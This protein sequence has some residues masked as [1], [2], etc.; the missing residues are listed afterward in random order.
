M[1]SPKLI[2]QIAAKVAELTSQ[3][4]YYR[5]IPRL[6]TNDLEVISGLKAMD[7]AKSQVSKAKPNTKGFVWASDNPNTASTYGHT[8]GVV[9]PLELDGA[10]DVVVDA[11][12]PNELVTPGGWDNADPYD[13]ERARAAKEQTAYT[14]AHSMTRDDF[15]KKYGPTFVANDKGGNAASEVAGQDV[16]GYY[17]TYLGPNAKTTVKMGGWDGGYDGQPE[18]AIQWGGGRYSNTHPYFDAYDNVN[19]HPESNRG[20]G[21]DEAWKA[22]GRPI[23]TAAAMYYGVGALN[24]ALGAGAAAGTGGSAGIGSGTV[25]GGGAA[26]APT[27]TGLAGYMGMAPG[28]ADTALNTG[29]L[30]TGMSLV[31]GKNIGDSLK[32]GATSALLSP[33]SSY[34]GDAVGGGYTG[35]VAGNT[36]L[37]GVQ[38]AINGQGFGKGLQDGLVNGLVSS[39]GT[40]MGGLAKGA[41]GN[42]FAGTAANS[43]TQSTLRGRDPKAT[44]DSLATQYASGELTDLT[45]LPPQVANLVVN[46]AQNRKPTASQAVGALSQMGN[47]VGSRKMKQTAVGG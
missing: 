6:A 46:L 42:N 4:T 43:L 20:N 38:G 19:P 18:T 11:G 12:T 41:T 28:Y 27:A 40:Y 29:A 7:R 25:L 17:D 30:N 32:T 8:G 31:R 47:A 15:L 3:P 44:L 13:A 22:V 14:T 16:G 34:V 10:P 36:V 24:G 35:Q 39:A 23:A 2:A 45:G 26:V 1:A 9:V 5:G 33:I 37:G 21:W